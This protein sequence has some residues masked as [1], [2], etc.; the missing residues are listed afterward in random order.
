MKELKQALTQF[1]DAA[2]TNSPHRGPLFLSRHKDR[3]AEGDIIACARVCFMLGTVAQQDGTTHEL[4]EIRKD[5]IKELHAQNHHGVA[6]LCKD[7]PEEV[8]GL[9]TVVD[10]AQ[11]AEHKE[12]G[13]FM[14]YLNGI[15]SRL[16]DAA[17]KSI[18]TKALIEISG[19]T[20]KQLRAVFDYNKQMEQLRKSGGGRGLVH[21]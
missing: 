21:A 8:R 6:K 11:L 9:I 20:P 3:V 4:G 13:A 18:N 2:I 19:L 5:V 15:E 16:G 17:Y 7:W 12:S 1:L 14:G 10:Q